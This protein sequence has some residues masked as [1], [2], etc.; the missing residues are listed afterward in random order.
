MHAVHCTVMHGELDAWTFARPF[1]SLDGRCRGSE[2]TGCLLQIWMQPGKVCSTVILRDLM[3]RAAVNRVKCHSLGLSTTD[4][5]LG[6]PSY[7]SQLICRIPIHGVLVCAGSI[8][9]GPAVQAALLQHPDSSHRED[10]SHGV[11]W[12]PLL[13]THLICSLRLLSALFK[14][15]ASSTRSQIS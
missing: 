8:G 14:L 12:F 9:K 7:L 10:R 5:P 1:I 4:N 3:W 11:F 15:P 6:Y 13:P 2:C